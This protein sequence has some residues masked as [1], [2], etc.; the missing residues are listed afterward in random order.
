M[1]RQVAEEGGRGKWMPGGAGESESL[2]E[3]YRALAG[4][5]MGLGGHA[6][7]GKRLA[8]PP[9]DPTFPSSGTNH[10]RH[11]CVSTVSCRQ[12]LTPAPRAPACISTVFGQRFLCNRS[13]MQGL[14]IV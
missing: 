11:P 14:C 1:L 2:M 3:G 5:S 12:P 8:K 13:I 10:G 6:E 7:S 9:L 4:L